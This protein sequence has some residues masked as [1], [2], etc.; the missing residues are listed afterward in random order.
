MRAGCR[1]VTDVSGYGDFATAKVAP[2]AQCLD[3][4]IKPVIGLKNPAAPPV[5]CAS[6]NA[7]KLTTLYSFCSLAGCTDGN[8]PI[9]GMVQAT[10]G[11]FYGTTS[12]G[13]IIGSC[14]NYGC[15]TV[16]KIT[17]T[18]MLTTLYSFSGSD[19]ATPQAGLMQATNGNLYGDNHTWRR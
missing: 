7:G 9:G 13:G 14:G 6:V 19:G 16:F 5:Q 2:L 11:N 4:L 15:G 12:E 17:P 10:D 18:G 1:P 8:G 3:V